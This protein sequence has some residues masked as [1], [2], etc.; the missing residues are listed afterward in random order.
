[1]VCDYRLFDYVTADP[2]LMFEQKPISDLVRDKQLNSYKHE[3]F[4]QAMY[5]YQ[6]LKYLN[7]LWQTG[8]APWKV[9]KDKACE[10]SPLPPA[11]KRLTESGAKSA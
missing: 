1:M 7:R 4:W 8:E 10:V 3:S 9:W 11:K 6:E 5:N 2:D